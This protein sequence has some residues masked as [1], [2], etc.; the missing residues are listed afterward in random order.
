[1]RLPFDRVAWLAALLALAACTTTRPLPSAEPVPL[2]LISVDALRVDYLDR[3]DTP[4]LD[5]LAQQGVRADWMNPSYPAL[6]FPNHFTLVTGLRPDHHGVVHN[7]MR[8]EGLGA[9]RVADLAAVGDG[10]WWRAA[11]VWIE[12]EKAGMRTAVWA[13]PGGAAEIDGVRPTRW[14]P[15]NPDIGPARRIQDVVRW[16]QEPAATRPRFVALYLEQVDNAGHDF[17]PDAPQTRAAVREVDAAIG[18]LVGALERSRTL[19]RVNLV[20]VS[21]HGMAAVE[22]GNVVTVEDIVPMED[23]AVVSIGQSVGISPR[24]GRTEVV[25]A[26]VLGRHD[27]YQCW[28]K[29]E[30]PPRWHYGSN[31]RVPAIVCQM[32]EGWD[33]LPAV[34]AAKR[35]PGTTR[36]SHGYDPALPSMRAMFIARGPAFRKGVR[37]AAFDNVDVYPLMTRL[38]HLHTPDNDGDI[39]PLLPA[40]APAGGSTD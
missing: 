22:S 8:E 34:D 24:A 16:L 4:N 35:K 9:F 32:D 10:R 27:H 17:G 5:R 2:L 15:Y 36:G 12:A 21:D 37:L 26:R 11:P 29:G 18:M 30:L 19:D 28:R 13:W 23:A 31:P 33:A 38:L 6:T 20:L 14:V 40:L 39:A 25:E 7:T 1:M 3:G